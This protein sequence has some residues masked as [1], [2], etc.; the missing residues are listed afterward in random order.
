MKN[1]SAINIF[2]NKKKNPTIFS[3]IEKTATAGYEIN[4]DNTIN[5]PINLILDQDNFPA[6]KITIKENANIE[7]SLTT[8]KPISNLEL[9]FSLIM[10]KSAKAKITFVPKITHLIS[11]FNLQLKENSYLEFRYQFK[12]CQFIKN[13]ILADLANKNAELYIKSLSE[14]K[15][16]EKFYNYTK[17]NHLA[18]ETKS[19]QLHKSILKQ[20][21]EYNFWGQINVLPNINNIIAKKENKNLVLSNS[22]L[23]YSRPELKIASENIKCSHG[24]SIGQLDQNSL[25]YLKSRG[26]KLNLAKKML[27][28]AFKVS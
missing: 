13:N 8:S 28:N 24:A 18:N 6:I 14:L 26:I 12:N 11:N 23:V 22:A 25:F 1:K 16:Q 10:E 9:N 15:Q 27:I 5:E 20:H 2:L 21:S 19:T 4:F 17:I 7:F 3:L